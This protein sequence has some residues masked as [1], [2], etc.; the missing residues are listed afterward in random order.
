[1]S[2]GEISNREIAKPFGVEVVGISVSIIQH[3]PSKGVD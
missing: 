1:M 3:D 2:E